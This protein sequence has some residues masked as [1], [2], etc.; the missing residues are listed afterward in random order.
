MET[1]KLSHLRISYF[2]YNIS[3]YFTCY[4][5]LEAQRTPEITGM[6]DLW[7]STRI[8]GIVTCY[9][10]LCSYLQRKPLLFYVIFHAV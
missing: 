4:I 8:E 3:C 9:K 5:V 1:G 7:V 2:T 10:E 6:L